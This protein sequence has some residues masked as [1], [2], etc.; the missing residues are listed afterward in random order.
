MRSPKGGGLIS[1]T[2]VVMIDESVTVHVG[3]LKGW[4]SSVLRLNETREPAPRHACM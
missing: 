4:G 2:L 1:L 3:I